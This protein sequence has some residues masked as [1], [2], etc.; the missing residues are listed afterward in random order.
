MGKDNIKSI[1]YIPEEEKD[2]N[3]SDGNPPSVK[4]LLDN[5]GDAIDN[6]TVQIQPIF[7]CGTT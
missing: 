7:N 3:A 6:P 2:V 5:K 4:L 1:L